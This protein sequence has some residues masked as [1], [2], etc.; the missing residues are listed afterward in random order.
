MEKIWLIGPGKMGIEYARVL[1][2]LKRNFTVIG[3]S[4]RHASGFQKETKHSVLS[5][6][7]YSL[8]ESHT[9]LP[10][11]AIIAVNEEALFDV[12]KQAILAGIKKILLE[13]PGASC[14]SELSELAKLA[15]KY[16]VK[17]VIAYNRRFYSSVYKAEEIINE[18]GGLLSM[19]FE[20]TEWESRIDKVNKSDKILQHWVLANSSHVIDTVFFLGGT[21]IKMNNYRSSGESWHTAG[22]IYSGAGITDK[23]V[24]FSYNA[25]WQ[26]AG[27]WSIE[28]LTKQHRIYLKPME[29]LQVQNK[30]DLKLNKVDIDDSLDKKFKPGFYR[31]VKAFLEDD[32][33]RFCTIQ[34]QKNNVLEIY[35]KIS[36]EDDL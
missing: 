35:N 36:G 24:L 6:G 20:F 8:L 15:K 13:K 22:T 19:H 34:E 10:E 14:A 12:T 2:G 4:E 30:G 9:E 7:L 3:R 29:I 26:S 31:Q 25:N 32:Y 21:P 18:D 1:N 28:L 23:G 16:S 17:I 27:R 11:K 5:G 33:S